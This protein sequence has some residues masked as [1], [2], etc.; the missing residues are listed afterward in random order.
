MIITIPDIILGFLSGIILGILMVLF[1]GWYLGGGEYEEHITEDY[2]PKIIEDKE[3]DND[4]KL[5]IEEFIK[6]YKKK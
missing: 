1:V 2:T 3:L 5:A 6:E 4:L